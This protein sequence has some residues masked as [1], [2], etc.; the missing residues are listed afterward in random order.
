[1]RVNAIAPGLIRDPDA[2]EGAA[3]GAEVFMWGTPAGASGRPS[4]IADAV[5]YLSS[6]EACFVHGAILDVDGGRG[7]TMV[8]AGAA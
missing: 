4:D 7:P 3:E 1:M 2:G 6:D 5:V 8:V